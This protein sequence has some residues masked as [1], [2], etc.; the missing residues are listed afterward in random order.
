MAENQQGEIQIL[1][2]ALGGDSVNGES[3]ALIAR[4]L[5]AQLAKGVDIKIGIDAQ[6]KQN[7]TT[8][9]QQNNTL[10]LSLNK[11]SQ[12]SL[13][14]FLKKDYE[15]KVHISDT[16][17]AELQKYIDKVVAA[18]GQASTKQVSGLVS[19]Q[20]YTKS[21]LRYNEISS[22]LSNIK[23]TPALSAEV[24]RLNEDF[25]KLQTAFLT[26]SEAGKA[27][28][29]IFQRQSA[30]VANLVAQQE[31]LQKS[32]LTGDQW[33]TEK[34]QC[35]ATRKQYHTLGETTK[36][37]EDAYKALGAAQKNAAQARGTDA[38]KDA[39]KQMQERR[40]ELQKLVDAQPASNKPWDT[41]GW[42]KGAE[43]YKAAIESAQQ[44]QKSN[45][46]VVDSINRVTQAWE[47]LQKSRGTDAE[48]TTR[49]QYQQEFDNLTKLIGA[50]KQ[51][52]TE[53]RKMTDIQSKARLEQQ[54]FN[55]YV[56]NLNPR[57]TKEYAANI[58]AIQD[59]LV[60]ASQNVEGFEQA[61]QDAQAGIRSFKATMKS[62]GYEG[63]N[64]LTYLESK[65]KTLFTY[66]MANKVL[67]TAL[68]SLTKIKDAVLD[69]NEA[70]TQLQIIT[71]YNNEEA[72]KLLMTYNGMAQE[73]GTTTTA[74]AEG[75]QD[76]LRQGYSLAETNDLL[77]Q[78]MA[79]SIMGNM[80]AEEA[81]TSLTAALRG[82]QL[83]TSKASD[84]V[85]K[86]FAVDMAAATSSS[87]LAEALAKTAANAK[88]AGI[89]LDDV[90][91][92]L[93]VVNST[94]QEDGSSTGTF[95]NTMLARIGAVK[96]GRLSDPE[97]NEDLSD[98]ESTLKGAGIQLRK[99]ETEFRNFGEVLDEVASKWDSFSDV[100]RRA[101]ASAFAGTRQQTRFLALMAGYQESKEYAEVAA[102]SIG[103][104][105]QKMEI[106]QDS[107]LAK[108]NR[109][110]AAFEKFSEVML[111]DSW[112][113]VFYDLGAGA[114]NLASALDG[115]PIKIAAIITAAGALQS[116]LKGMAQL[117]IVKS[118]K[119]TWQGLAKPKMTGFGINVAIIIEEPA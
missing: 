89:S 81:T 19:G 37:L 15:L 80:D 104:S 5:Q 94:L 92:Q 24:K 57:A 102:D 97:T 8:F 16:S 50:Q 116:V 49:T 113:G 29:E 67:T 61:W 112:I 3:G 20:S 66:V 76:W 1:V 71:G 23:I 39:I 32:F 106:Y 18:Q 56:D 45:S 51:A 36:E 4:Q 70:M 72:E 26:N 38:E 13:E 114:L 11:A 111:P 99:S 119:G 48:V 90:I 25:D 87:K 73:L 108:Q 53:Y 12:Q 17:K 28:N 79:L 43:A 103:V 59:A 55:Q 31:K 60:R 95:Y 27:L 9:L 22:K 21:E 54:K 110:T 82:Y 7:L 52:Q 96:A 42:T 100:T 10:N 88:L 64:I 91:G 65:V 34:K 35:E 84:V 107:L 98:V 77:K 6:S 93:A 75:A 40:R 63:Q 109:V 44:Y 85:D 14:S 101:V 68:G 117:D 74:V 33:L 2:G 47:A 86:F 46:A 41:A 105:A 69:L 30:V 115:L 58:Q 118:I 78:S 62:M 83:E